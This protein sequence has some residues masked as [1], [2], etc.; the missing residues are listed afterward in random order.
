MLY[1]LP[2]RQII[3]IVGYLVLRC[4]IPGSVCDGCLS[5]INSLLTFHMK[6]KIESEWCSSQCQSFTGPP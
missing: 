1:Y 6:T 3:V 2:A 4:C 5:T